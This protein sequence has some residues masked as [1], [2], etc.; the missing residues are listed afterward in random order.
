MRVLNRIKTTTLAVIT[1]ITLIG[2]GGGGGSKASFESN[3]AIAIA[4]CN[5]TNTSWTT[6]SSGDVVSGSIN[7]QLKFDH[8]SNGNKQ[9]CLVTTTPAGSA[10]VIKG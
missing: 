9:V 8:D 7:A 5:N 3:S 6:L 1:A 4:I 2:C 10:T